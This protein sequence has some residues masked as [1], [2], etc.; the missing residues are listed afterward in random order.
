MLE[1]AVK[2][3]LR[4]C[5]AP[6]ELALTALAREDNSFFVS[7]VK[8]AEGS[9]CRYPVRVNRAESLDFLEARR[10]FYREALDSGRVG[11]ELWDVFPTRGRALGRPA[12]RI[13]NLA[14]LGRSRHPL[15]N[16]V[17]DLVLLDLV[18]DEGVHR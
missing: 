1:N 7:P 15:C 3:L 2:F 4:G 11:E 5:V 16:E 9:G 10:A 8:G 14:G 13:L 18:A 12:D 17:N 6:D